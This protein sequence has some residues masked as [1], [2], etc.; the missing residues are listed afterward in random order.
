MIALYSS[1]SKS[2]KKKKN[3]RII[4]Y[5]IPRSAMDQLCENSSK[6]KVQSNKISTEEFLKNWI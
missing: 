5:K 4:I 6:T 2:N 3:K 1:T